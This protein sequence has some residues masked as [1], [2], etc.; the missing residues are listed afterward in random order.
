MNAE[1]EGFEA[2][3]AAMA[4]VDKKLVYRSKIAAEQIAA[5][6]E[7]EAKKNAQTYKWPAN[8]HGPHKEGTGPGPNIRTR[9][10]RNGIG[11]RG[12]TNGFLGYQV[13]VGSSAVYSRQVEMGGG[14][15]KS[16][17]KYPFFWPAVQQVKTSG[18]VARIQK[19]IFK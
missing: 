13:E 1:F 9:N 14:K 6:I 12:T 11:Y 4:K 17:V 10:L 3:K 8:Y 2:F 16:G 18:E 19:R 7:R 15:W 5:A